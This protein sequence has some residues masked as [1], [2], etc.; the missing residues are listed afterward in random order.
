MTSAAI[1]K[2][3]T[4]SELL[5][6]GGSPTTK[7]SM[8]ESLRRIVQEVN[9]APDLEQALA[10]IVRRV[11]EVVGADA[12]SVYLND[13]ENRYHLLQASEGLRPQSVGHVRIELGRGLVGLVSERAEPINLDDASAHPR[14][15]RIIDTGEQQYF[16]FLG[17]PI[18]Q[19]RKVQGVLVLRQREKRFYDEDEVTFVI[20]L[21]SQLAGAIAYARTNGELARLQAGGLPQCFRPGVAASPASAWGPPWSSTRRQTSTPS[22]TARSTTW[23]PR[24]SASAARCRTSQRTSTASPCAPAITSAPRTWRC[25]TPGG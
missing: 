16:G 17:A 21:A 5:E 10:V 8:L 18:I 13:Y 25:S 3:E 12:C 1:S 19:N 22:R 4:Q 24:W 7:F 11:K 15:L 14:Y 20:T 2:P 9:D 6:T 23:R